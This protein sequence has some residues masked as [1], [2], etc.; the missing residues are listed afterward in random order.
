MDSGDGVTHIVCVVDGTVPHNLCQ[1][2]DIAGR[3]VTD[4]LLTL[5]RARGYSL[6]KVA[7][8]HAIQQIKEKFC[9]VAY[10]LWGVAHTWRCVGVSCCCHDAYVVCSL[11][12]W[13]LRRRTV[14]PT[15]PRA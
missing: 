13:M 12:V 14:S 3:H 11:P 7:D 2:L 5:L 15:K 10:V 4:K 8:F 9:Y 6:N 1:R